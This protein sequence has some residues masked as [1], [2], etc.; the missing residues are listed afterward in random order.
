MTQAQYVVAFTV[1]ELGDAENLAA[2]LKDTLLTELARQRAGGPYG[3]YGLNWDA[4]YIE[5]PAK[6]ELWAEPAMTFGELAARREREATE[7]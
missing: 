1:P 3:R 7:A 5:Q 4:L 6:M 2:F